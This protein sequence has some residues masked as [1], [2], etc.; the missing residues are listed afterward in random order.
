MDAVETVDS[1]SD[2]VL[3]STEELAYLIKL[4]FRGGWVNG[5]GTHNEYNMHEIG[6][7]ALPAKGGELGC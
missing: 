3:Y 2:S 7:V 6:G 4:P 1:D 5:R